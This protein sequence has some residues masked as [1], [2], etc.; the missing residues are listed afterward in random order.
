MPK[1]RKS[2][3]QYNQRHIK[4]HV[5]EYESLAAGGLQLGSTCFTGPRLKRRFKTAQEADLWI[6]QNP[7]IAMRRY[8]CHKC[9]GFHLTHDTPKRKKYHPLYS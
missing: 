7:K 9:R 4:S 5:S 2:A 6:E 3:W 8:E 1:R